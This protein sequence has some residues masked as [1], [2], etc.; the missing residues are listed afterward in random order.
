VLF[1][2]DGH[3]FPFLFYDHPACG[4]AR[5]IKD[6]HTEGRRDNILPRVKQGYGY[7]HKAES[8]DMFP[9][10]HKA[11]GKAENMFPFKSHY[12]FATCD[13]SEST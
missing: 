5:L 7:Q 11:E 10:K 9:F 6:T 1:K 13:A 12:K 8:E 4:M 2:P 3:I